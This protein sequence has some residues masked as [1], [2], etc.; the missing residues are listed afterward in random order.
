M[1]P[2]LS[3]SWLKRR[4]ALPLLAGS[5]WLLGALLL[6][7]HNLEANL[8][9]RVAKRSAVRWALQAT[10]VLL[11]VTPS[12]SLSEQVVCAGVFLARDTLLTAQHCIENRLPSLVVR[13]YDGKDVQASAVVM[14]SRERDLAVLRLHQPVEQAR[15][16]PLSTDVAVGDDVFV[17]GSPLGQ[18]FVLT[19]GV[20]SKIYPHLAFSN[21]TREDVLGTKRQQILLTDAGAISGNSGGPLFD[22]GGN[23]LGIIVRIWPGTGALH[24][25]AVGGESIRAFLQG[26]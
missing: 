20:I 2:A 4:A 18:S 24:G 5:L 6:V 22:E 17:I 7:S 15:P 23:L 3:Y 10:A 9:D 11:T 1:W 21:P 25:F 26:R 14:E 19:Q 12:P 8:S 13:P 16:A